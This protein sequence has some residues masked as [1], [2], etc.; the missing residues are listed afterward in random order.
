M[1]SL[2]E[3]SS[4][5]KRRNDQEVSQLDSCTLLLILEQLL[6][7]PKRPSQR[8]V[9]DLTGELSPRTLAPT[10]PPLDTQT[11]Y[12]SAFQ[13]RNINSAW[14]FLA[15]LDIQQQNPTTKYDASHRNY[16]AIADALRVALPVIS[17]LKSALM[18]Q[19]LDVSAG[20]CNMCGVEFDFDKDSEAPYIL[21]GCGAVSCAHIL[22]MR[23]TFLA[24]VWQ[25]LRVTCKSLRASSSV[26]VV[27]SQNLQ[28]GLLCV[29]NNCLQSDH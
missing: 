9:I 10:T 17:A 23:L 7:E 8:S 24:M 19:V 20:H 14:R 4:L 3:I 5:R 18:K 12:M 16:K 29:S 1:S 11:T 2:A 25:M 21:D 28:H 15:A 26:R 13:P 22:E 27:V 6:N